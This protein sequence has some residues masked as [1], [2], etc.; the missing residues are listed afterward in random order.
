[1]KKEKPGY[2]STPIKQN[3]AVGLMAKVTSEESG[4]CFTHNTIMHNAQSNSQNGWT[5]TAAVPYC[6]WVVDVFLFL[7]SKI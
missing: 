4:T 3:I 2:F 1:M 7:T 6:R 5:T